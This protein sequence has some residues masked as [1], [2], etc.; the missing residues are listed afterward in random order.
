LMASKWHALQNIK[1]RNYLWFFSNPFITFFFF[2]NAHIWPAVSLT[3]M[4]VNAYLIFSR[5]LQSRNLYSWLTNSYEKEFQNIGLKSFVSHRR[6]R[7]Q[8]QQ[9]HQ[10]TPRLRFPFF[11]D[12]T[13]RQRAIGSRSFDTTT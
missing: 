12:M 13:P 11:S 5:V 1:Y 3:T 10:G 6:R 8:N 9:Q 7:R 4:I 2:A